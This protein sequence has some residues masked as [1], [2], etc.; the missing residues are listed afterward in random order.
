MAE[1]QQNKDRAGLSRELKAC[2]PPLPPPFS[3][4]FAPIL[5]VCCLFNFL[6]IFFFNFIDYG[7]LCFY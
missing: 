5:R 2:P 7:I 4:F 6:F 1:Q 3:R